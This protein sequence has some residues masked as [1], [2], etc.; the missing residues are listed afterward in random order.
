[1]KPFRLGR[2]KIEEYLKLEGLQRK[3]FTL[4]SEGKYEPDDADW[5]YKDIPHLK[6]V[7][8]QIDNHL[9]VGEDYFVSSISFQKLLGIFSNYSF[10]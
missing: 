8:K 4:S 3:S 5:N 1:M 2:S 7:H 6:I 10:Y 9:V